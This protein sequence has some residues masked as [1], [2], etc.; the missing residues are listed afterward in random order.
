MLD[1]PNEYIKSVEVTYD[2][3]KLFQN[4]VITSFT[5]ETSSERTSFIGYKVGKKFVLEQKDLRLVGFHGKE[6]DAIDALGAYFAPV[7]APTP[8]IPTKKLPLVGGNG[9]VKWDDGVFDGVRKIYIGQIYDVVSYVKF[10]YIKGK[11][12]VSGDAH[13]KILPGASEVI[14]EN[15][16]I[17]PCLNYTLLKLYL[18]FIIVILSLFSLFL[19]MMNISWAWE[20]TMIRV[21]DAFLLSVHSRQ[22]KGTHL[23]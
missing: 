7:Q 10:D 16:K 15:N 20:A 6:G 11:E 9:G 2:K 13:G 19:R 22:T 4:T 1:Y 5:F 21:K 23:S 12:L 17:F 18:H 8:L 14:F 3:P